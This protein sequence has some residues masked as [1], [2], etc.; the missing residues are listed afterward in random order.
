MKNKKITKTLIAKEL[1]ITPQAVSMWEKENKIP[2][3]ACIDLEASL[4]IK[5]K[6]LRDN[7]HLL[8]DMFNSTK[9]KTQKVG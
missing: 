9:N 3:D 6:K 1:K 7:P 8:F 2:A 5:P 4:K